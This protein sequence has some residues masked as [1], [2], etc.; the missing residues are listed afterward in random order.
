MKWGALCFAV[1][2]AK[3]SPP[4]TEVALSP[5]DAGPS[6]VADVAPEAP[7][8]AGAGQCRIPVFNEDVGPPSDHP[9]W[10]EG[11]VILVTGHD[12]E[13][14]DGTF[15]VL[16]LDAPLCTSETD[17]TPQTEV[18]LAVRGPEA[19]GKKWAGKR[20]RVGG[21]LRSMEVYAHPLRAILVKVS[22]VDAL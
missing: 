18:Q 19:F 17:R 2:C 12:P 10:L 1:A 16:R 7:V 6:V 8:D 3:A 11:T 5:V 15:P 20:L 4:A 13:Q 9:E 14:G 21:D 22:H